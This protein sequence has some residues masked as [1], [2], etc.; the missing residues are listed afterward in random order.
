MPQE[1][2]DARAVIFDA[3]GVLVDSYRAHFE[4]WKA[5]GRELGEDLTEA[6][7]VS[8]F[9][10]RNEDLMHL[11]WDVVVP[12]ADIPAW[13]DWKEAKYREILLQDFPAMDGAVALID[14]LRAAGFRLAVGSSGPPE[15][16]A[17]CIRG[18]GREDAFDAT[19]T[20]AEVSR[21]KP[22]PEVFLKAAAKLG[23]PPARCAVVEDAVVGIEAAARAGTV[24]IGL[25][26]TT[27]REALAARAAL[28]VDS[29]RDL[30]PET[31]AALID[32]RG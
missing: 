24:P 15:N 9:G 28:V 6:R 1:A 12:E 2:A 25:T 10:M 4:A 17:V 13:S 27:T 8:T 14:A 23:V 11:L 5:M 16:V 21:G 22:D 19:V 20:G 26:G 3:D 18:L 32:G 29:L 30:S 31:I 7:F